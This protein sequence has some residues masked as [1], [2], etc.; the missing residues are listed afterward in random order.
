LNE[1]SWSIKLDREN[2]NPIKVDCANNFYVWESNCKN[3]L[4]KLHFNK[5]IFVVD[6][7]VR[8]PQAEN[9]EYEQKCE[10]NTYARFKQNQIKPNSKYIFKYTRSMQEFS[11]NHCQ[12]LWEELCF[13]MLQL[14]DDFNRSLNRKNQQQ[15]L[16]N[17]EG[18]DRS[19]LDTKKCDILVKLPKAMQLSCSS[20]HLHR[21]DNIETTSEPKVIYMDKTWYK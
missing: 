4:A 17:L 18:F 20:T 9:D 8:C 16:S 19:V 21:F 12:P 6:F 13:A 5:L 14:V 1:A 15:I 7:P 3:V 10:L 2:F 11:V